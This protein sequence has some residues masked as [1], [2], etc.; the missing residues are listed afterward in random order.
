LKLYLY[1]NKIFDQLST[2][3]VVLRFMPKKCI[4]PKEESIL[5]KTDANGVRWVKK[6]VG[7]G[8]H[9]EN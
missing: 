5:E 2:C 4:D 7:G 3:S 8:A 1:Y 6:Y 9:F